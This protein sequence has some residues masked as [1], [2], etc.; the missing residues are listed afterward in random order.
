MNT[1]NLNK[2][3]QSVCNIAVEAG[4]IINTYYKLNTEVSFKEDRS[5]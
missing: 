3:L 2:L 1:E 5:P 4:L